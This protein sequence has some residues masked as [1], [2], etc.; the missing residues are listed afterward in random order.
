[1]NWRRNTMQKYPEIVAAQVMHETGYMDPN[2]SSVFNSSEGQTH[3]V[4]LVIG[5]MVR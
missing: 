2:L 5:V 3:L 1:M 4:K